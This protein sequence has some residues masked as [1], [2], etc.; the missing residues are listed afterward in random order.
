MNH[1]VLA[2]ADVQNQQDTR[3]VAIDRVGVADLRYPITVMDRRNGQ[4]HTIA[5]L[6][7]SV[8]LPH[9]FKGTH[10]SR[11][12]EVLNEHRGEITVRSLPALLRDLQRRLDAEAAQIRVEFPYFIEKAAPITAAVGLMDYDCR[13]LGTMHGND[14]D[15]VLGVR[16]PVTSLCPC[17]KEISDY[18]AHNQRGHVDISLRTKEDVAG[19]PEIMWI[20]D[21][22]DLG[23]SC[24]SSPVFPLLKRPD[25]RHV[26]MQ[27]FENPAF[28]EDIVRAAALRLQEDS[29]VDWFRVEVVNQESIHNHNA[30]AEVEWARPASAK[31]R[32]VR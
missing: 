25:E 28:V 24:A 29:R 15:F 9:H 16:I 12:L 3:G 8:S 31:I 18:G 21:V 22:I 19:N 23:D 13:F 5:K 6:S 32:G 20:E 26:T 1:Q 17:S 7:L 30:F 4:Q 2:L 14:L 27:A 10:M 11:F